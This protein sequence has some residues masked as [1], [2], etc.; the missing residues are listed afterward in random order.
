MPRVSIPFFHHPNWGAVIECLPGCDVAGEPPRYPP[1]T[2]GEYLLRQD[3]ARRT[4]DARRPGHRSVA[5]ADRRPGGRRPSPQPSTTPCTTSG[6]WPSPATASTTGSSTRM[7]AAMAEFF[8]LPRAGQAAGRPGGPV[9]PAGVLATSAPRPRPTPTAWR[10]WPISWRRSTPAS[11]RYRPRTTTGRRPSSSRRTSG[12]R[13]RPTCRAVWDAVPVGDA[14]AGRADHGADGR[15][16]RAGRRV[17]RPADRPADG[18]DHGEPLPGARPRAGRQT[19]SAAAPTPTTARSRCW[20]P[21]ASPAC[22]CATPTGRG[23]RRI[24]CPARSTSTSATCW[25][26]GA[27]ATG[28]RRGTASCRRPAGRRTPSARAS[29]TSTA[30]TPTR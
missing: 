5:A 7:F 18:V 12:P 26:T 15:G 6:S 2:A 16:A 4:H 27:A 28:A 25:S 23:R 10:R 8:A 24:P 22:S 19:S 17:V 14:G 3:R 13:P 20:P 1:V 21:T 9:E 30:P 11:T 29:P